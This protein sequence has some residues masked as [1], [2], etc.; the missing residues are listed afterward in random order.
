[1]LI[2]KDFNI[3]PNLFKKKII[4]DAIKTCLVRRK[5]FKK[6]TTGLYRGKDI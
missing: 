4:N 5:I 3:Q 2:R 6:K 1:M